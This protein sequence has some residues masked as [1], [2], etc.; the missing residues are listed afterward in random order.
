M[1]SMMF[2]SSAG[3]K[4]PCSNKLMVTGFYFIITTWRTDNWLIG[5]EWI[6]I[7]KK[8]MQSHSWKPKRSKWCKEEEWLL[9][10][11]T[12]WY[13][14]YTKENDFRNYED[15]EDILSFLSK[16]T[17]QFFFELSILYYFIF[18]THAYLYIYI[19]I[20]NQFKT[21]LLVYSPEHDFIQDRKLD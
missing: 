5:I 20:Y 18:R 17:P 8:K 15:I 2:F 13:I 3:K 9:K 4:R 6:F 16:I 10:R 19:Y 11:K 14:A 7:E 1:V 21:L 12:Y